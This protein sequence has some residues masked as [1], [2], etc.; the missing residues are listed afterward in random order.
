MKS[1]GSKWSPAHVARA[2]I[3][4][5]RHSNG[6]GFEATG[7]DA[8]LVALILNGEVRLPPHPVA[9]VPRPIDWNA[10]PLEQ[11]NWRAQLH[12]LRWLDPLRRESLR[13][14]E[15]RPELMAT[16][17][18]I[19]Q[20]WARSNLPG[21]SA[22]RSAWLSM[23]EAVRTET[24]INGLPLTEAPEEVLDLLNIHGSWIADERHVGHSNHAL[25]QHSALFQVGAVVGN[26]QWMELAVE[27]LKNHVASAIDDEGLNDEGAV[28]YWEMN[29]RWISYAAARLEAEGVDA[30]FM[31]ERLSLA[32]EALAFATRPDGKYEPLGDSDPS[33]PQVYEH[34]YLEYVT[35][36]GAR[37]QAP[38]ELAR[39]YSRGFIFGHSGWGEIGRDFAQ[40]SFYSVIFGPGDKVHGHNDAGSV[41]FFAKKQRVLVDAGK[42]AYV[43]S[44]EQSY[45]FD[46]TGHNVITVD[47][48]EYDPSRPVELVHSSL[49]D[50]LDYFRLEDRGYK[51]VVIRRL[52]IFS[53]VTEAL[54]VIDN[55]HSS[56]DIVARWRW[57]LAPEASTEVD[58]ASVHGTTSE[59]GF[60]L[61]WAGSRPTL[62]VARGER[63]PMEGWFS[64]SWGK[65]V[66]SDVVV[67][68]RKGHK[69]RTAVAVETTPSDRRNLQSFAITEGVAYVVRGNG[70]VEVV[71]V[72]RD[73][74]RT[75]ATDEKGLSKVIQSLGHVAPEYTVSNTWRPPS[76]GNYAKEIDDKVAFARRSLGELGDDGEVVANIRSLR[77]VLSQGFDQGAI[78][79]IRDLITTSPTQSEMFEGPV[80]KAYRAGFNFDSKQSSLMY[81][82]KEVVLRTFGQ[83]DLSAPSLGSLRSR[84]IHVFNLGSLSLP[85]QFQPGA[86][87]KLLV[88]FGGA[89]DRGKIGLPRFEWE[90]QLEI[91]DIPK[92]FVSDPTLDLAADLRLGWYLGSAR[93][94]A[95]TSIARLVSRY[96]QQL[97]VEEIWTMGTSGGGFA[98]MQVG[99]IIPHAHVFA[100]NPQTDVSEYVKRFSTKAIQHVFG[101]KVPPSERHRTSVLERLRS[102]HS[103]AELT[104]LLNEED[105]HHRTAH[106]EPLENELRKDGVDILE[107][108]R[109]RWGAG[110]VSNVAEILDKLQSLMKV[111]PTV[112][113]E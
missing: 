25:R 70:V 46:R 35:S 30:G 24:L 106:V 73:S 84:A 45:C 34:P 18:G 9:Q 6:V 27:R 97:G 88:C 107:V 16:W 14:P 93:T 4:A 1:E 68:T 59:G 113:G 28:R 61:L 71:I 78:A 57:H 94:D 96:A 31:R 40:E 3:A 37:G 101:G 102:G 111:A 44:S 86:G 110:H 72:G 50:E 65:L 105:V 36:N 64:P 54:L 11:R 74:V 51:G 67:A 13:S 90:R 92:L 89:Q 22:A 42:Y 81:R 49:S 112:H 52:I 47:G 56:K 108:D 12:M 76:T 19:V 10:D 15:R 109:V 77:D 87:K 39:V 91:F 43:T 2:R 7:S 82:G 20:E 8:K 103:L 104:I 5:L 48:A 26:T 23:I 29:W 75:V 21:K 55:V 83:D 32:A 99:A 41:T 17:D 69:S 62:E 66:P 100:V 33:S 58:G 98:A 85:M 60:S 38:T 53:R 95:H 63:R 80:G 79:G